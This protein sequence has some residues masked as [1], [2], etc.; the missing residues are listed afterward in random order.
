MLKL[1]V[2]FGRKDSH[3]ECRVKLTNDFHNGRSL[4]NSNHIHVSLAHQQIEYQL[5]LGLWWECC[6]CQMTGKTVQSHKTH[7]LTRSDNGKT[8]R[9]LLNAL[10]LLARQKHK[11]S[12]QHFCESS[13][14]KLSCHPL[15]LNFHLNKATF[16]SFSCY[17]NCDMTTCS[18]ETLPRKIFSCYSSQVSP[19]KSLQPIKL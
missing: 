16:L 9:E 3:F 11:K 2:L 8:N 14:M 6:L 15:L 17:W 19:L 1:L 18:E 10:R 4:I 5:Q 13:V 12:F 7:N